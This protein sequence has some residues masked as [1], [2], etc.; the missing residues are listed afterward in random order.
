MSFIPSIS[1]VVNLSELGS[2]V[3]KWIQRQLNKGGYNSGKEDG[4]YGPIT[5]KAFASFKEDFYL[6]YPDLISNATL[7]ILANMG[8]KGSTSEQEQGLDQK[9]LINAGSKTGQ[10]ATLP[11]V[12]LVYSNEW[13]LPNSF[14]TWGEMTKNL[15]RKPVN[16]AEVKN[17]QNVAKVFGGVRAKFGS[18]IG[19]TSGYRP[20]HLGIG[21]PN[22]Q[23][24]PGRAADIYPLNGNFS[25]LL[26]II[27]AEPA[28]KGIGLG[29]AKGFLHI[30][31]RPG[32]RVI[33]KY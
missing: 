4:V 26:E 30:D 17:I 28:I 13:I 7:E 11:S 24:I 8:A 15:S 21:V 33:F 14:M 31:L 23:H 32:S 5:A 16:P 25:K 29:Q 10:S 3:L 18:A 1:G 2:H 12:G 6:A 9:P 22:S 27:K 19:V 20:A